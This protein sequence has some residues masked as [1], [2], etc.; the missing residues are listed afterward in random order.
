MKRVALNQLNY[1]IL[2]NLSSLIAMKSTK[3]KTKRH[4]VPAQAESRLAPEVVDSLVTFIEYHPPR[5]FSRNLRRM[6]LEYLLSDGSVEN[7]HFNDLI[8]DLEGLF[9]VLD[10]AEDAENERDE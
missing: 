7:R 1:F 6:L 8:Y 4:L 10:T 5:R 3:Q 2:S 9:T